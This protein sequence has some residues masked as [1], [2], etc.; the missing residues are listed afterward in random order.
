[1]VRTSAEIFFF[2]GFIANYDKKNFFRKNSNFFPNKNRKKKWI[3]F[4]EKENVFWFELYF[5]LNL[6]K[7]IQYKKKYT[8]G[9]KI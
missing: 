2:S 1:M 9:Q 8:I 5:S 4:K 3:S 7:I 6:V